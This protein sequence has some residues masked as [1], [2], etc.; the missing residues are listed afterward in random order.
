MCI[1]AGNSEMSSVR[2]LMTMSLNA[3][4]AEVFGLEPDEIQPGLRV[5]SDL[6]MTADQAAELAALVA[7]YFDE[8]HIEFGQ[9]TTLGEILDR[10]VGRQFEGIPP[11]VF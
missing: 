1:K 3:I 8:L 2:A 10:V 7:E 9:A 6:R 11:E 4:F 5:F